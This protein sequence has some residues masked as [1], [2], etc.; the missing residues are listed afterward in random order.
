MCTGWFSLESM[1]NVSGMTCRHTSDRSHFPIT[2][3]V[4]HRVK[5]SP[6][7]RRIARATRV[8]H[9]RRPP[10]GFPKLGVY[11]SPQ[12][13]P[14]AS[15]R[16]DLGAILLLLLLRTPKRTIAF[17]PLGRRHAELRLY[18]K[19]LGI[20]T[21][22][23]QLRVCFRPRLRGG[24]HKPH[25]ALAFEDRSIAMRAALCDCDHQ[26]AFLSHFPLGAAAEFWPVGRSSF[27]ARLQLKLRSLL[28]E[29]LHGRQQL[30]LLTVCLGHLSQLLRGGESVDVPDFFRPGQ[31]LDA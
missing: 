4:A 26:E 13:L 29:S 25:V 22:G 14:T 8:I 19:D 30:R 16:A 27:A 23:R 18:G 7:R 9:G 15:S 2:S 12:D 3:P 6:K 11:R 21:S 10:L 1:P 20:G 5:F 17:H 31:R 24:H 28:P